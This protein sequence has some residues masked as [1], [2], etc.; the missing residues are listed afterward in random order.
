MLRHPQRQHHCLA[1][2]KGESSPEDWI[3]SRTIK[4]FH[5]H[6]IVDADTLRHNRRICRTPCQR[7]RLMIARKELT[8][9]LELDTLITNP[10]EQV[11]IGQCSG[12]CRHEH[13]YFSVSLTYFY[14][15]S[16]NARI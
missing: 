15:P 8:E 6:P 10:H 2:A 16:D 11:D 3:L 14:L 7:H 4:H 9:L 1:L 13:A 5:N 12:S